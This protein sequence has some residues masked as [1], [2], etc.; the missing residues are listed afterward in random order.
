MDSRRHSAFT[1][2]Q[3]GACRK[4]A[5]RPATPTNARCSSA[6][7]VRTDR[8]EVTVP[9]PSGWVAGA[10]PDGMQAFQLPTRCNSWEGAVLRGELDRGPPRT[11]ST[12]ARAGRSGR[13][14]DCTGTEG[15]TSIVR[16]PFRGRAAGS[17]RWMT[18]SNRRCRRSLDDAGTARSAGAGP[19][20][21]DARAEGCLHR[22]RAQALDLGLGPWIMTTRGPTVG[23][24]LE[25]IRAYCRS[26]RSPSAP[27]VCTISDARTRTLMLDGLR[28]GAG[29]GRTPLHP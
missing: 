24:V 7:I 14:T 21:R 15:R 23:L 16:P 25:L 29:A 10:V 28:R 9:E 18:R 12:P 20:R 8:G 26:S 1:A 19:G 4:L 22:K 5:P 3:A 2:P 13:P 6:V 17:S 27:P 11:R